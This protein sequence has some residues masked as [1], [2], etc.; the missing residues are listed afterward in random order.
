[1]DTI[2][3]DLKDL[4]KKNLVPVRP[5]R[6]YDRNRDKYKHRVR[7]KMFKNMKDTV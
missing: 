1:M 2:V 7:P 5:S 4:L 3:D 6:K